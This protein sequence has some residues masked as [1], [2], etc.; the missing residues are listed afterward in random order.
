MGRNA[1]WNLLGKAKYHLTIFG[2]KTTS[3]KLRSMTVQD[4]F[5]LVFYKLRNGYTNT[6]IS[7]RHGIQVQ[8]VARVFKTWLMTLYHVFKTNIAEKMFTPF[9][10]LPKPPP[11]AFNNSLLK[12]T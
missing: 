6:D 3:G 2:T 10:R 4:Q 8:L 11:K 5:L 9:H 12:N 7:F 1:T